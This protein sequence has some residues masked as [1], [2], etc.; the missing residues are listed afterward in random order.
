MPPTVHTSLQSYD[1]SVPN[2][3]IESSSTSFK[4]RTTDGLSNLAYGGTLLSAAADRERR[5][6]LK[7]RGGWSGVLLHEFYPYR[8][9]RMRLTPVQKSVD[10]S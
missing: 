8:I 3:D 4:I 5:G 9:V 10:R 7:W 1:N 6:D 2:E